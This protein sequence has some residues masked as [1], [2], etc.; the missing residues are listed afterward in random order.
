MSLEFIRACQ[1]DPDGPIIAFRDLH[2]M[3]VDALH[4]EGQ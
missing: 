3:L 4:G 2:L 1:L